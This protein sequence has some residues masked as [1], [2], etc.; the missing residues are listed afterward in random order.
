MSA[1][2]TD[3]DPYAMGEPEVRVY[4]DAL[5]AAIAAAGT[6]GIMGPF[7]TADPDEVYYIL[8]Q[9]PGYRGPEVSFYVRRLDEGVWEVCS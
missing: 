9:P 8:N 1:F 4:G 2:S 3:F 6:P 7:R 5:E